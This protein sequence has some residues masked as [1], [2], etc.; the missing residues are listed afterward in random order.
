MAGRHLQQL[1]LQLVD[2]IA[3]CLHVRDGR[4]DARELGRQ[5]AD[6]ACHM[7]VAPACRMRVAPTDAAAGG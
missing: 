6:G 1:A 3:E 7:W 2:L 5:L 4:L